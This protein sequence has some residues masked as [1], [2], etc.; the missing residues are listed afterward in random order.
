MRGGMLAGKLVLFETDGS[1]ILPKRSM[2]EPLTANAL[3]KHF[4]ARLKVFLQSPSQVTIKG[5]T[6]RCNHHCFSS[7]F[8]GWTRPKQ[9]YVFKCFFFVCFLV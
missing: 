2:T 1:I 9:D 8:L 5:A 7:F 4:V 6:S 3:L